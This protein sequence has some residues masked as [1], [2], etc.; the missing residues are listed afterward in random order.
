MLK[1]DVRSIA[2]EYGLPTHDKKDSTGICFIGERN[3]KRFLSQYLPARPGDIVGADGQ[4]KG[5]H[6]GLMYYTLGQRRGLGIG[7]SGDG[8]RW[9]VV[10]KDIAA[11]VLLVDQ[12]EDSPLLYTKTAAIGELHWISGNPPAPPGEERVF[13]ARLRHRQ[14]L[15]E[16]A[17]RIEGETMSIRFKL[18]QRAVTPGQAAV[19]YDG[20]ICL[21][22][23]TVL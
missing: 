21:G 1:S 11:N 2:K 9:F 20:D 3:F 5:R 10:G 17:A 13:K 22:G 19:L 14:P 23:G 18:P 4:V 7:G 6:D 15:I 12:G 16:A 8:R